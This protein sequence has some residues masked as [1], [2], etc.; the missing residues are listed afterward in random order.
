MSTHSSDPDRMA[1]PPTDPLREAIARV[2]RQM[3]SG[4]EVMSCGN[5][6]GGMGAIESAL[7]GFRQSLIDLDR[8]SQNVALNAAYRR[9][10]GGP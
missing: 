4:L 6:S 5:I 8:R 7:S 9:H 3:E 1:A 2:I 10:R